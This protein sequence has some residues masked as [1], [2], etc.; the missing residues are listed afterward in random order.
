M[1]L[2]GLPRDLLLRLAARYVWWQPPAEAVRD[3]GRV[4]GQVMNLG[5]F[6]DVRE[7]AAAA[8]D[9]ALREILARSGPGTFS[10]RSWAYWH[11][12]LGLAEP[13]QV[14]PQ[15]RRRTG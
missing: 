12:R 9:E 1:S 15:P 14:P 8:G 10:P 5:V 6:E 7:L 3:P 11:Y 13:G 2:D 4:A